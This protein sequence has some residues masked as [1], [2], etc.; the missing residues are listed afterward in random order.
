MPVGLGSIISEQKIVEF[1][2]VENKL[3][4]YWLITTVVDT[5]NVFLVSSPLDNVENGIA[6][7]TKS[8]VIDV[9]ALESPFVVGSVERGVWIF[10]SMKYPYSYPYREYYAFPFYKLAD[11]WY[12][13][14]AP[15]KLTFI[16]WETKKDV[17]TWIYTGISNENQRVKFENIEVEYLGELPQHWYCP[18]Y[19]FI[20]F[21][22]LFDGQKI[23]PIV[24][25]SDF[26]EFFTKDKFTD[27]YNSRLLHDNCMFYNPQKLAGDKLLSD[28][29]EVKN[30]SSECP[31][32]SFLDWLKKEDINKKFIMDVGGSMTLNT[33][34]ELAVWINPYKFN[35]GGKM[36]INFT[37]NN[38][39]LANGELIIQA[40]LYIWALQDWFVPE[41]VELSDVSVTGQGLEFEIT[42]L[43]PVE[44][45]RI[46]REKGDFTPFSGGLVLKVR[47]W[48]SWYPAFHPSGSGYIELTFYGAI[49]DLK[50]VQSMLWTCLL[51]AKE[52]NECSKFKARIYQNALEK[53]FTTWNEEVLSS[54]VKRVEEIKW[55][56]ENFSPEKACW[57]TCP[58][59]HVENE[60]GLC[61]WAYERMVLKSVIRIK[62]PVELY[63][64]VWIIQRYGQP[65]IVKEPTVKITS[66]KTARLCVEVQNIGM[67]SDIFWGQIVLPE[68][69]TAIGGET[70]GIAPGETKSIC[71]D[72]TCAGGIK[73]EKILQT[74]GVIYSSAGGSATFNVSWTIEPEVIIPSL[75]ERVGKVCVVVFKRT[76]TINIPVSGVY[77]NVDGIT[78]VTDSSGYAETEFD[79]M[80]GRYVTAS[81]IYEGR[82][83]RQ[84]K[85]MGIGQNVIFY[86]D[87]TPPKPLPS[88]VMPVVIGGLG[89][90]GACGVAV[91]RARGGGYR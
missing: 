17:F 46:L 56:P 12:G 2:L 79:P 78:I 67:S 43:N 44:N 50:K 72:L 48:A 29:N 1:S 9:R 82:E 23:Y 88:W 18:P 66:G 59:Q 30:W 8:M 45:A 15:F 39:S 85:W 10:D 61:A 13:T 47:T 49:N 20:M 60:V 74:R 77:V 22:Y 24:R 6:L 32:R 25:E 16:D 81:F 38:D 51:R 83:Y 36:R 28:Y 68:G 41:V 37:W 86:F 4:G 33:A 63:D 90:L 21:P 26:K 87:V 55:L 3:E 42:S 70:V 75:A 84:T 11:Y 19:S 57:T 58:P 27:A 80:S 5:D 14:Y 71:W 73:E 76:D 91:T 54:D 62:A 65:K 52:D 35:R 31:D 89:V 64:T 53:R 69:I 34:Q 7:A 40:P